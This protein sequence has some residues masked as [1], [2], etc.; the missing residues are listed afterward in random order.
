MAGALLLASSMTSLAALVPAGQAS[1]QTATAFSQ[2]KFAT[3]GTGSELHLGLLNVPAAKVQVAGLEQAFSG[4]AV[5]SPQMG[6]LTKPICATTGAVVQPNTVPSSTNAFARAAAAELGVATNPTCTTDTNQVKVP[7]LADAMSPPLRPLVSKSAANIPASP[8]INADVLEASNSAIYD[9][10]VCPIGQPM[11]YG[12]A[13]AAGIDLLKGQALT[14]ST[15]G[16]ANTGI[17]QSQTYSYLVANPDGTFGVASQTTEVIAPITI[18]LTNMASIEVAIGAAGTNAPVT[19]IAHSDGQG[20]SSVT[21]S[22]DDPTISVTLN[23][24]G[25]KVPLVPPQIGSLKKLLG[26]GGLKIDLSNLTTLLSSTSPSVV[27]PVLQLLSTLGAKTITDLV[28]KLLTGLGISGVI[29]IAGPVYPTQGHP[30]TSTSNQTVSGGWDLI[31]IDPPIQ[32][33]LPGALVIK[34]AGL[35]VGHMEAGSYLQQAFTC[36]IPVNKTANPM[37]VQAG[38]QFTWNISIPTDAHSLDAMACKLTHVKAIDKIGVFQGSPKFKVESVSN[39]GSYDAATQ[40]ITWTDLGDYTPG[41]PPIGL[42]I[43][44]SV[45]SDSPGGILQD[46]VNV[47]SGVGGCTGGATHNAG[48][49][50]NLGNTTLT[51]MFTLN[52]PTVT[53]TAALLAHTGGG[54][55]LAWLGGGLL[56]LAEGVRRVLRRV[57]RPEAT[58]TTS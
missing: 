54:T 51:G 24:A 29:T 50:G 38:N 43:T 28:S 45:P 26:Q 11:A 8:V 25:Q 3:F 10:N 40:T 5:A 20:H 32:I 18:S 47:S 9:P 41:S 15:A 17:A 48:L 30:L 13:K 6:G 31:A 35:N 12:E 4:Q 37:T 52:A 21:L 16:S 33:G 42:T 46:I 2:A 34:L 23:A 49:V 22:N 53:T 57:R 58:S 19:L 44:V 14:V 55:N 56:V 39:G 27:A 7:T 1:A 36:S